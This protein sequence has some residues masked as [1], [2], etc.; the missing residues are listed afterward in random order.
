MSTVHLEF[1]SQSYNSHA[2]QGFRD[3]DWIIF[4]CGQCPEYERRMNWRTGEVRSRHTSPEIRH[5]GFYT[6]QQYHELML[7]CN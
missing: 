1:A 7:N 6:P 5:N 3:G 4:R 2:C